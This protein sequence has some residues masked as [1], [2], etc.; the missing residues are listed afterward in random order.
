MH[1]LT[2]DRDNAKRECML[3]AAANRLAMVQQQIEHWLAHHS[4]TDRSPREHLAH[5]SSVDEESPRRRS[6][7]PPEYDRHVREGSAMRLTHP[8]IYAGAWDFPSSSSI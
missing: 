3:Q 7:T 4:A 1:V 8:E 6:L 2:Y 5:N